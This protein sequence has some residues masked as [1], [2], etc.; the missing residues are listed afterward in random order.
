MSEA[1]ERRR[2]SYH[3]YTEHITN[4][5]NISTLAILGQI[6]ALSSVTTSQNSSDLVSYGISK[7]PPKHQQQSNEKSQHTEKIGFENLTLG[8]DCAHK[9]ASRVQDTSR[10]HFKTDFK[11]LIKKL[12]SR[13]KVVA[14]RLD[15]RNTPKCHKLTHLH[16]A[17]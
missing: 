11:T 13:V 2:P 10:T 12:G 17:H 3:A 14:Q 6:L 1:G 7:A 15:D 4:P 5:F 9:I 8:D 16:R